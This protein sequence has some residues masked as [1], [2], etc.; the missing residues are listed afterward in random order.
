MEIFNYSLFF[1]LGSV[2]GSF[3]NVVG[4]RIPQGNFFDSNRSFC[5]NCHKK[6]HWYELIPILSYLVQRG[7]CRGCGVRIHWIYP[8]IEALTGLSFAL[9]YWRFGLTLEFIFALLVVSLTVIIIVT[10]QIYYLIPNK[11]LL[12]FLPLV[13]IGRIIIP[14]NPWW[15]PIVGALIGFGLL[16]LIILLSK[17]GMGAGDMKYFALL[18]LVFGHSYILLVFFLSSLYGAIISTFLIMLKKVS[19]Q[20]KVPFG[21]YISLA[22]L[23]VLFFG[24]AIIS[25]YLT[26][27]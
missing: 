17:G 26:F 18:G 27:F 7:K 12:F 11:I 21:P 19:R 10:D 5:P 20:S 22:A 13:I 3:Y 4:L 24:D 25:G 8:F 14:L 1:I 15:S 2:L 23:T 6:L 16:F 9:S